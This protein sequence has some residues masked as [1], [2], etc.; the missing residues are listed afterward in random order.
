M[1]HSPSQEA[2][3]KPIMLGDPRKPL[4]L[5]AANIFF[6]VALLLTTVGTFF[7]LGGIATAQVVLHSRVFGP[8]ARTTCPLCAAARCC[9][10]ARANPCP[11]SSCPTLLLFPT[12]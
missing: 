8:G 9:L 6:G 11:A 3:T 2:I 7:A 5:R 1:P 10:K 12:F 4:S